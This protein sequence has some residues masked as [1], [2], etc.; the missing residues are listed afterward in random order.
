ML[1]RT[2]GYSLAITPCSA[3]MARRSSGSS[4]YHS[5]ER[6]NGYTLTYWRGSSSARNAGTWPLLNSAGRCS[7]ITDQTG[8]LARPSPVRRNR[9]Y[10]SC[11]SSEDGAIH[12]NM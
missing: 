12:Q 3:S 5:Y 6:T 9:A 7:A 1:A 10:I 11:R 2:S 8:S 4:R